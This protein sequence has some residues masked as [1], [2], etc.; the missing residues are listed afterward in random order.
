MYEVSFKMDG[1]ALVLDIR[2][3]QLAQDHLLQVCDGAAV[4]GEL[5]FGRLG[6]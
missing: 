5:E 2:I 6:M 1:N 4:R 3:A